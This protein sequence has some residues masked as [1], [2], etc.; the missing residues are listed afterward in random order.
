MPRKY[1]M[2]DWR[3]MEARCVELYRVLLDEDVNPRALIREVSAAERQLAL[4]VRVL[5]RD[6]KLIILDEPTTALTPPEVARLFRV[7]LN[8]RE[9]GIS[10]IFVEGH[11]RYASWCRL[12]EKGAFDQVPARRRSYRSAQWR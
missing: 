11:V 3:T 8:L 4:L 6:A 5:S 12:D 9:K 7:I 2:P 1:F 10:F